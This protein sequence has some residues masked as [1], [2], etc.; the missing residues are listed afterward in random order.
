MQTAHG[1]ADGFCI[2]RPVF[3]LLLK[4]TCKGR[5]AFSHPQDIDEI[6]GSRTISAEICGENGG[7][8]RKFCIFSLFH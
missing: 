3:L 4:K 8:R 6:D 5:M 1:P 7:E 2:G